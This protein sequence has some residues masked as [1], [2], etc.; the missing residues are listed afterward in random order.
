MSGPRSQFQKPALTASPRV[1][2][3]SLYNFILTAALTIGISNSRMRT[4]RLT[5]PK[6]SKCQSWDLTELISLHFEKQTASWSVRIPLLHLGDGDAEPAWK[7]PED[8]SLP[9]D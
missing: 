9:H 8:T 4:L 7:E 5:G 3:T 6:G 2:L 1:C